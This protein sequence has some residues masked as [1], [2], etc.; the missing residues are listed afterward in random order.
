MATNMVSRPAEQA[1]ANAITGDELLHR[2]KTAIWNAEGGEYAS[3]FAVAELMAMGVRAVAVFAAV[4]GHEY[5][6]DWSARNTYPA[7]LADEARTLVRRQPSL[8]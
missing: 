6:G 3:D 5:S 1:D 7:A 4:T 2:I 8:V